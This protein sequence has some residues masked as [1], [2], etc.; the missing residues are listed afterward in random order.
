MR[1]RLAL[2]LACC[3]LA[4][5]CSFRE[6]ASGR[7]EADKAVSEFHAAFNEGRFGEIYDGASDEFRKA[8]D[9]KRF[10]DLLGAVKRKL[11]KV[12]A[13]E[14]KGWRV[15]SRNLS[16]YVELA[17]ST[18]FDD[19]EAEESFTFLVRDGKAILL[20]YNIQSQELILR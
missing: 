15:N 20:R 4:V 6:M 13:S 2:P 11:G 7:A 5:G 12:G 8:T 16:T 10:L 17:Q 14:N 3:A 19:S 18:R 9:R 1:A